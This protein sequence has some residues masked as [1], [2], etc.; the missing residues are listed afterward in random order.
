M[1]RQSIQLPDH[2]AAAIELA[3]REGRR[4]FSAECAMR[5][6]QSFEISARDWPGET[7]RESEPKKQTAVVAEWPDGATVKE[8]ETVPQPQTVNSPAMRPTVTKPVPSEPQSPV[9]TPVGENIPKQKPL[10]VKAVVQSCPNWMNHRPGVY[11][12]SCS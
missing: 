1:R 6:E 10:V 4:S 5:L 2:V 12:K 8:G 3:A 9:T 7:V 11:C